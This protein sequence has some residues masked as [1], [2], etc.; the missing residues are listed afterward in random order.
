[1][2]AIVVTSLLPV[3]F[4]LATGALVGSIGAAVADGWSSPAGRRLLIAIGAVVVLFAL[5]QV[6]APALRSLAESLGR[7]VEGRLRT[8]VMGA[9]LA[10]KG[11]AHLE[12]AEVVDRVAD[13][14]SIGTGQIM[15]RDAIVGMAVVTANSL[16]GVLAAGLLATYRWWLAVGLLGSY[17]TMTWVRAGQLRRTVA[18]LRGHSRRF[19]RSSYFRD[20]ALT[21]AAAKELR[22][23]G[24]G[25]WITDRFVEEWHRAM[26]GFWRDRPQ[27]RWIPP[28]CALLLGGALGVT[29]AL[30]G[31][32]A[33][34]GDISLGQLTMFA[35]AAT[36]VAAIYS[37]GMDNLNISYGTAPV[38]AAVSLE[39]TVAEPR[40]HLGGTQPA[41]G[42][43]SSSIRFEGVSF[44]YPGRSDRVFHG[45]D[46]EIPAG[47]SLAI[48][49]PNG[50]G[51]TTLV[52]LLARLY[53]PTEGRI[54]VDGID[55]ADID[56][57]AWHRRIAAIFQDFVH[58]ELSAADNV[59]FGAIE[60][61][62]DRHAV[63]AAAL[64]AGADEI[65]DRLPEGWDT[66]LSRRTEDG[67]DLS[68]GQWQRVALARAMFAV[69][70]GASVLILDEPTAAVDV[71]AEAVFYSRFLELTRGITTIVISHRFSTVRRADRIVVIED[72]RV[73]ETGD[74]ASLMATGGRYAHMFRL[75]FAHLEGG[76]EGGGEDG[77]VGL[78]GDA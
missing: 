51:K 53:D 36:G 70:A 48:V 25:P 67:T 61:A 20:L 19:R 56:A 35:A 31:R 39:A 76:E 3:G 57:R 6:S 72:G 58:Y 2:A 55:L 71:R 16:A 38:P 7:R 41:D 27:G 26:A 49:G 5:Q 23:F 64:R 4:A 29:Y 37:V 69:D 74:H 12:D 73:S 42:L 34:R 68:G 14:Q 43:P 9:A 50:A 75:Q 13:A 24:L 8:R 30:L 44:R 47:R 77:L 22:L 60:R 45:L 32:S 78:D 33:A 46:L 52:K 62:G 11:V 18:A 1:V 66:V 10:P 59:G 17:L 63:A 65:V 28:A 15:V 21:P 54:V 40:F